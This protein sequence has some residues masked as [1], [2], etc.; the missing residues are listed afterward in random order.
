MNELVPQSLDEFRKFGLLWA[1]NRYL[2]HPRG[3]AMAFETNDEGEV[4]GLRMY[5][6]GTEPWSFDDTDTEAFRAFEGFLESLKR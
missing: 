4:T 6:D 5:G 2:F 3:F 1:M